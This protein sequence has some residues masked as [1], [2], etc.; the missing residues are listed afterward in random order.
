MFSWWKKRPSP[1]K[2][3]END[4]KSQRDQARSQRDRY[5]AERDA[6][7][8]ELA[9]A[10]FVPPGHFYSPIPDLDDI[11]QRRES[12]FPAEPDAIPP[13]VQIHWDEQLALLQRLEPLIASSP[14]PVYADGTTRYHLE[15][16]SFAHADGLI[17]HALIRHLQPKRIIEVGSGHS[18]CCIMD[19]VETYLPQ[20]TECLFIEPYPDLLHRLLR[21]EDKVNPKLR[22][23]ASPV[24]QVD[25]AEFERLESRD[26]LFV[27]SSH[28]S[29]IGSDVNHIVF[30]ILP[31]L[32]PGVWIHFHDIG[33][34]F[35]YPE[36][37]IFQS[38]Y[39]WNEC[40]LLR[41]FLQYNR[42]F[43]IRI[44]NS[45]LLEGVGR[46]HAET[47]LSALLENTGMSMWLERVTPD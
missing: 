7:K 18:S 46:H 32:Q 5:R 4:L 42:E 43:P 20:T 45:P 30:D 35:E 40:Y 27:D 19:T 24:Q 31:R 29:K 39:F 10:G 13:G 6:V 23:I 3:R 28:I 11:R 34:G 16:P 25:L 14:F 17:L 15:N 44:W 37:W 21:P 36:P 33:K 41:A 9:R 38:R 47:R 8:A 1:T 26:I 22:I 12:I 2:E